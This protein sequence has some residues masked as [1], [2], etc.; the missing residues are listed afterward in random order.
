MMDE[1]HLYG[2][3]GL[4]TYELAVRRR[5]FPPQPDL[6]IRMLGTQ[7][8]QMR[9]PRWRTLPSGTWK[10]FR[11]STRKSIDYRDHLIRPACAFPISFTFFSLDA[12]AVVPLKER[13]DGMAKMHWVNDTAFREAQNMAGREVVSLAPLLQ[14]PDLPD[15]F[16]KL[17][18]C[19]KDKV[20][21][22]STRSSPPLSMLTRSKRS[23][24]PW[25]AESRGWRV[26]NMDHWK[27]QVFRLE[28]NATLSVS[29]GHLN[30]VVL[31]QDCG[32]VILADNSGKELRWEL[33][34]LLCYAGQSVHYRNERDRPFCLLIQLEVEQNWHCLVWKRHVG[35]P[36]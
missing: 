33:D 16:P 31:L 22:F 14:R 34:Q 28:P 1:L 11:G 2:V 8:Q 32:M 25:V 35:G 23:L 30:A 24:I 19:L 4:R 18:D 27:P 5:S 15:L 3:I 21:G 7:V 9:S 10:F 20:G 13:I 17:L 12:L 36:V 26:V 6:A 29:Q